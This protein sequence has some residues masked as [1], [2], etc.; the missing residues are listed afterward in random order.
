MSRIDVAGWTLQADKAAQRPILPVEIHER[1]IDSLSN[2]PKALAT[3]GLV[4]RAMVPRTRFHLFTVV[5]LRKRKDCIRLEGI[6]RSSAHTRNPI[7]PLIRAIRI[8]WRPLLHP[9]WFL[10][11]LMSVLPLMGAVEAVTL[12]EFSKS[13]TLGSVLFCLRVLPP[14]HVRRLDMW[15]FKFFPDELYQLISLFPALNTFEIYSPRP[16]ARRTAPLAPIDKPLFESC[17]RITHLTVCMPTGKPA[18]C[19]LSLLAA[20]VITLSLEQLYWNVDLAVKKNDSILK[21]IISH[22]KSTLS[23]LAIHVSGG[24]GTRFSQPV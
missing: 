10:P 13:C 17:I 6:L 21:T 5:H 4:C 23:R 24:A 8:G 22:S 1:I 2:H 9:E 3:C 15:N 14:R 20:P 16:L 7:S 12:W 11:S 18:T 19:I